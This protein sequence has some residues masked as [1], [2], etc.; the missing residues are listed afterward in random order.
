MNNN[1]LPV[2]Y[3][4]SQVLTVGFHILIFFAIFSERSTG[5][6]EVFIT[7]FSFAFFWFGFKYIAT[8]KILA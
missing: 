8:G 1:H 6:Q 4:V 5:I 7:M 3:R 2:W